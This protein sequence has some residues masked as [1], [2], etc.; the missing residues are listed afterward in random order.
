MSLLELLGIELPIIQAPLAGVQ[1]S[2][3]T[4]A[5][6]NPHFSHPHGSAP[7]GAAFC[8]TRRRDREGSGSRAANRGQAGE[9]LRAVRCVE[10]ASGAVRA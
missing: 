10:G 6:S 3:L 8:F 9:V 5:V 1:D 4:I 2:A 7:G